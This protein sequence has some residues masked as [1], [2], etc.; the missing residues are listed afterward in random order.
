M[1]LKLAGVTFAGDRNPAIKKLM[2]QGSVSFEAEPD[3]EHDSNA[4]KVMYKDLHIGYVPKSDTA[5]E[6]CMKHKTGKIIDYIYYDSDLKF[7]NKHIGQFQGM[8]FEVGD[9]IVEENG[10]IIG[11]RYQRVTSFINYFNS[12]GSIDPLINWAFNNSI[13]GTFQGYKEALDQAA[14]NG[15]K[16]HEAIEN[17]FKNPTPF[18]PDVPEGF[19]NFVKKYNPEFVWGEKRFYDNNLMITGKPDFAGYIEYKGRRVP[20]LLDWKSS[21]R[22][23][24]KHELQIS[25]Y[26]KNSYV[27]DQEIEGAMVVAFGSDNKQGYSTKWLSKEQLESNYQAAEYIRKAMDSMGVY[28]NEY[29]K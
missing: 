24:K 4:V 23:N 17:Y 10:R 7:N 19:Y 15:T 22:P 18:P 8:T 5:Q 3:N 26:A 1:I 11:A 21:K 16:M 13:D 6:F 29:Y 27:E 9:E 25:I 2:P 28:I 20:C 14:K 12:S